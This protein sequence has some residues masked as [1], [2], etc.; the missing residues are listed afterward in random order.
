[1]EYTVPVKF[2]IHDFDLDYVELS[3]P[4]GPINLIMRKLRGIG[5]TDESAGVD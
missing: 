4:L 5:G 2:G 3:T 1:M